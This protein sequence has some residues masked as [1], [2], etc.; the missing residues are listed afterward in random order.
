MAASLFTKTFSTAKNWCSSNGGTHFKHQQEHWL[1][2]LMV[3]PT[4]SRPIL[5]HYLIRPLPLPSI[6]FPVHWLTLILP[7]D[8]W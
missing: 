8:I 5:Q 7:S 6:S 1:R 2:F 4:P 3:F